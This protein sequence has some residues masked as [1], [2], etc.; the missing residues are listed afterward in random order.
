MLYKHLLMKKIYILLLA[1]CF[2]NGLNAQNINIPDIYFKNML[3][4]YGGFSLDKDG[5]TINNIDLN[6]DGEIQVN[7]ALNVYYLEVPLD[8]SYPDYIIRD[9]T[10]IEYFKNLRGLNCEGNYISTLDV[11]MLKDLKELNATSSL[12]SLNISNLTNL[13]VLKISGRLTQYGGSQG[14]TSLDLKNS[15]NLKELRVFGTDLGSL[16][17]RHLTKLENVN[18]TNNWK[19][20]SLNLAQLTQLKSI[21]CSTNAL[22]SLNV[23]GDISLEILDCNTNSLISLD[24]TGLTNLKTI[25]CDLNQISSLN[26]SGMKNLT[27]LDCRDNNLT[28]LDV[29]NTTLSELDFSGNKLKNIALP[30]IPLSSFYAFN[31]LL[32]TI[33][34]KNGVKDIMSGIYFNLGNESTLKYICMDNID[35]YEMQELRHGSGYNFEYNTYC[36]FIPGGKVY[37]IKGNQKVDID[38][39]GC[40]ESDIIY[41]N[42][43]FNITN[44]KIAGS[45]I[46][47]Y[48]GDYSIYV[49]EGSH[50]ITP[51]LE[52]TNYF[53]VT[54]TNT[55]VTFP[56]KSSPFI[57]NFCITPNGLHPDLEIVLLPLDVARP[58][59]DTKYKLVYKNKGNVLQSGTINLAFEDAVLDVVISNPVV[60]S[61]NTNNLSWSFSNLKPFETHEI[62]FTLNVNDPT[63][64]PAVNNGAILH[65]TA[66]IN[67]VDI[68]ETPND[69]TF[70]FNQTVVGSYD[71]N[72]KTC[73]EGAVITPSL[74]GEYVHYMIRFENKGTYAAQNIV[75]KDM[76]DLSKFDISTLVPTSSSHSYITKISASNKVEFIFEN[77]NLPFDDANNDGYI[78]FKIK[79]KPTLLVG[80]AFENEANIYF[81]YNFPVLTNKAKSTFKTLESQDFEFSNYFTLYPNPAND[82]LNINATQA[83]EI[84]SLAIYDV[85]GQL[86]IAVPNAKTVS[87]IDISKLRTGNYFIKVKSDKG[88]SSMK[89]IKN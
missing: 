39:N 63:E 87:N 34:L 6:K 78:A 81:D 14:M 5:N 70:T 17:L 52:N 4:A 19:L 37:E 3:R 57:Q 54:P 18:I 10:G 28:S 22:E 2:F 25:D 80:D 45:V 21:V 86:V 12:V 32:E 65:Y 55:I 50:T 49:E 36:T 42:L 73:L 79:T 75:V 51:I 7:E 20:V 53:M 88:S 47:N 8:R 15:I 60:S 66:T 35:W 56:S 30:N 13:E 27:E 61:Q 9:L 58:G 67:S 82:V 33:N 83:I 77:I 24:L 41:P 46:S 89:F 62:T 23:S 29:T 26:V 69:N 1:L 44:G 16:D 76:I 38:K 84:K 64:T 43:K 48:N 85:L 72:D 59:F 11:S 74:I 71:P 40:D 31:N 68:D